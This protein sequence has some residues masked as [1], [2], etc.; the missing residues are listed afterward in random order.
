MA[1]DF[2]IFDGLEDAD[3]I[4]L[5]DMIEEYKEAIADNQIKVVRDN[6]DSKNHEE[7]KNSTIFGQIAEDNVKLMHR[8][9][10]GCGAGG[11]QPVAT[12]HS[13]IKFKVIKP[14]SGLYDLKLCLGSK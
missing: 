11:R 8:H 14:S 9:R 2:M 5:S 6:V 12:N 13:K 4:L 1:D 10:E 3:E 7:D